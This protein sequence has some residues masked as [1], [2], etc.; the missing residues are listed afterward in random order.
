MDYEW[1]SEH[2]AE[3]GQDSREDVKQDD[4]TA[5]PATLVLHG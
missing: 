1:Q 5:S 3:N 2:H 4:E